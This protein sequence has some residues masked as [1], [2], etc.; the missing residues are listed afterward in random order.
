MYAMRRILFVDDETN[1]L[2]GLRRMLRPMRKEW[3]MAFASGGEEALAAM[4][5]KHFD[6]IVTDMRMPG[7][8]GGALLGEVLRK[9]PDTVRIVLS[10][11]SS[12]ES[13]LKS[14]GVAH[15]FLAKPCDADKLKQTIEHAFALRDLLSDETLKETLSQMGS[16][17]SMPALYEELMEELQH[18]DASAHR[19]GEIVAQDPGMTVKV[20]QLVNSA[21]FGLSRHV[22]NPE[23]AT[24][25]LGVD[26][27]KA[28]V[29]SIDVFSQFSDAPVEGLTPEAVQRH[30]SDTA[31]LAKQIAVSEKAAGEVVDAALM[32]GFLHDVGKLI[33]AQNLPEKYQEVIALTRD[34][35]LPLCQA[36]REVLGATHAEVGAYL[37][38]LWGL[39]N[40]IVEA[41]AFHHDPSRS[42]NDS[43]SALTAVHAANVLVLE[44]AGGVA[45]G[46]LEPLDLDYLTQVGVADRVAA[47]RT[48][49]HSAVEA[50]G[51]VA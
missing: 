6:V 26:T 20:L 27:M 18:P 8:D 11:H 13:T 51:G 49:C 2:D 7:M 35:N 40:P 12:K 31:E 25:L 4:A 24:A 1:V 19:V 30:C 34:R 23:Q 9:H 46:A 45:D 17:P 32:A 47:W 48:E 10:G 14:I 29:L 16:V 39:P 50:A 22:A 33:L 41:T 21:F 37:L 38:G 5:D 44:K 43:F 36:E 15:Q 3:E 42:L 28:L